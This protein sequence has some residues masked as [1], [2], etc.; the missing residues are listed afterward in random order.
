MKPAMISSSAALAQVLDTVPSVVIDH[1]PLEQVVGRTLATK[2]RADRDFP[3]FD[4][5]TMDGIAI[6]AAAHLPA[7][8]LIR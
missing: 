8:H 6:A 2:V 3:P 4:R 1:V 7:H 5:V